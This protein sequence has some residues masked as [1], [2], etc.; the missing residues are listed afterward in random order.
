MRYFS[1][2]E[3]PVGVLDYMDEQF[4]TVLDNFRHELGRPVHP[5]PLEAG[6]VRFDGSEKSRHYAVGRNSDAGDFFPTGDP[7]QAFLVACRHFSG[8]GI[9]F[10]TVRNGRSWCMIHGDT[11]PD[12]TIWARIDGEYVY[13]QIG[14]EHARKFWKAF[15]EYSNG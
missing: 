4:L 5:S 3:F 11:R 6:W 9:Y 12:F 10:D 7:L 1:K 8:V 14:G 2:S 15:A 13:P